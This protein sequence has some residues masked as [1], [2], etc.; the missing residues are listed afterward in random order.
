MVVH[1]DLVVFTRLYL[2]VVA[3]GTGRRTS[4][5]NTHK[6]ALIPIGRVIGN[7]IKGDVVGWLFDGVGRPFW[8]PRQGAGAGGKHHH[9]ERDHTTEP[10]QG[11]L[12]TRRAWVG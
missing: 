2:G 3:V 4:F 12:C 8:A 9:T 5:F 1:I 10:A 7:G 11:A 6:V